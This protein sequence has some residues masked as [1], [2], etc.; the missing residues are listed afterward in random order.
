M[1]KRY[2][3]LI[4]VSSLIVVMV[5]AFFIW[6]T[7]SYQPMDE[8]LEALNSTEY[9]E[10]TIG[11]YILFNPKNQTPVEGLIFYPGGK[12]EPEAY[13]PL[14]MKIA[15]YGYLVALVPMSFNL[16]FFS[17]NKA[18]IVIEDYPSIQN[19]TISG[20]S[21]GGAMA[22][23]YAFNNPS[24]V[25]SLIL[26]AGYPADSDDMSTYNLDVLITYGTE[27]ANMVENIDNKLLLLPP[28]TTV[29][30]IDGGNHA[31]FGWYG[32]QRGD[33][34]ATITRAEQQAISINATIN[35]LSSF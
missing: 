21:L 8:A 22:A 27:N 16:A 31:Y 9:V 30:V 11:D 23:R 3:T 12:V 7:I 14:M 5:S 26:Y 35:F 2:I 20:H 15:E 1:K 13:A 17:P 33:G 25:N 29:V 28:S 10:V 24:L 18:D 4:T 32:E 19:W 6:T 34:V